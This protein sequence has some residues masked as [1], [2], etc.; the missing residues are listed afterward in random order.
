MEETQVSGRFV[1]ARKKDQQPGTRTDR[2][3][4]DGDDDDED[5]HEPELSPACLTLVIV[6]RR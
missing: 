4:N 5:D 6:R 2:Q 3:E 1:L